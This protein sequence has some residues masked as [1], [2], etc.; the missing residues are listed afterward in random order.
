MFIDGMVVGSISGFNFLGVN[1]FSAKHID[2]IMKMTHY[3]L[4]FF[5]WRKESG[6]L[7]PIPTAGLPHPPRNQESTWRGKPWRGGLREMAVIASQS[8]R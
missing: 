4:S 8:A 5:A 1:I 7:W 3:Q 6:N 2:L